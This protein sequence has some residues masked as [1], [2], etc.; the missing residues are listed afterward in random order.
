VKPTP[1]RHTIHATQPDL[2]GYH[3]GLPKSP[4]PALKYRAC[5]ARFRIRSLL[6]LYVLLHD[7]PP[8]TNRI[9]E[10]GWR[11]Q[12]F[13]APFLEMWKCFAQFSAAPTFYSLGYKAYR[14]LRVIF[15]EKMNVINIHYHVNDLNL[16]LF[17]CL[18]DDPL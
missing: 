9:M 4:N 5:I 13:A 6:I 7:L 11:P 1:Q 2:R 3:A 8:M 16:H 10:T 15:Y 14:I 18:T 17:A 12:T